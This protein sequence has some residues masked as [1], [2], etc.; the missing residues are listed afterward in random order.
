MASDLYA[1]VKYG[2]PNGQN[3][4]PLANLNFS[5]SGDEINWD[6]AKALA[7]LQACQVSLIPP[8]ADVTVKNNTI[9]FTAENP[10][11]DSSFGTITSTGSHIAIDEKGTV[12]IKA[13]SPVAEDLTCG[14]VEVESQSNTRINV[15][16]SLTINVNTSGKHDEENPISNS[17]TQSVDDKRYPAFS[18]NVSN[19]GL[20]IECADGDIHFSGK[21]IVFNAAETLSLNATRAINILSGFEP[22]EIFAKAAAGLFGFELPTSGGG[23]V[24]IKAGKFVNDCN[25]S[26]TTSSKET[27]KT[28][29][30]KISETGSSMSTVSER[31]SGDKVIATT[32]NVYI[33]AGQKMRIEAQ[34]SVVNTTGPAVPPV[35]GVA[36]QEA[37]VISANKNSTPKDTAFKVEVDNGD[38][39]TSVTKI[40]DVG[41]VTQTGLIGILAGAGNTKTYTG[42]PGDLIL[43]SYK[44]NILGDAMK[45]ASFIGKTIAG[46][47]IGKPGATPDVIAAFAP[48]FGYDE[49]TGGVSMKTTKGAASILG[50]QQVG[51][52]IGTSPVA[53]KNYIAFN[54]S[55]AISKI[56]GPLDINVTGSTTIKPQGSVTI[57]ASGTF[58][59]KATTIYLN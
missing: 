53:S 40:G 11:G 30:A 57:Q 33:Q 12:K 16:T 18:I 37:L 41:I 20:D 19:G 50:I 47:G 8:S 13:S 2:N 1:N 45:E 38:Y 36:Q 31:T 42:N 9:S 3:G 55:G 54:P 6:D 43:K 52:G 7:P 5:V 15:G 39:I 24:V 49:G 17:S 46:V 56:T 51:M 35:W 25:T 29:A 26:T 58:T 48:G 14:R 27:S 28:G 10:Y 23:E 21:N 32:G 22:S 34:G 44:G 59:V 4:N